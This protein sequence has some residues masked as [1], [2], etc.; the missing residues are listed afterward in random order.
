MKVVMLGGTRFIGRAITEEL[1]AHGHQVT[2]VHRGS[3]EPAEWVEVDHVHVARADMRTEAE[4]LRAIG[5]DAVVDCLAMTRADAEGATSLFDDSTRL[6]VLS[7]VDVYEAYGALQDN[8]VGEPVP[9]FEDSPVRAKRYPYRGV[10]EGMDDYEKLDVEDVYLA[11]GGTVLRLPMVYGEHDG[12]RREW[13]VL[14]RVRAG[15]DRIPI[16]AGTWVT[17]RGYVGDIASGVRHTIE[18]DRAAGEIFNLA[19]ARSPSTELWA[20]WILAAAG[21]GAELVRVPDE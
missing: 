3:S 21:S 8:R 18:S 6:I 5:A 1:V 13:P 10:L 7:S 9:S 12:Q 16:G 11:R 4:R 20:R 19:E 2:V 17:S 14:R 15:R